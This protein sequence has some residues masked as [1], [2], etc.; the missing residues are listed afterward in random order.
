M[1]LIIIQTRGRIKMGKE[2]SNPGKW[3]AS[4]RWAAGSLRGGISG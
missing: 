2:L 1:T 3:E 4:K